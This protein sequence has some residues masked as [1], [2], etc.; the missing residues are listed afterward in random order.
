[1]ILCPPV[2][3][4]SSFIIAYLCLLSLCIEGYLFIACILSLIEN[5]IALKRIVMMTAKSVLVTFYILYLVM[6]KGNG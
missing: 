4:L 2:L 3:F 5:F 6:Q 1:M